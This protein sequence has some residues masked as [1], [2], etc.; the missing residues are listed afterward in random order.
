MKHIQILLAFILGT[1]AYN[2]NA[3]STSTTAP[4][5]S[6]LEERL[7]NAQVTQQKLGNGAVFTEIKFAG[8]LKPNFEIGCISIAEV[9]NQF[10]PPSLYLAA[11]KCIQT[12]QYEKA[13]AL[14]NTGNGFA[15]YDI[16]RLADISARGARAVLS[17]NV[18][19]DL[20]NAQRE[21]VSKVTKEIGTDPEKVRAYCVELTRI[22][23]PT[24]EP[25]WAILHGIGA[26]EEP[27][28]GPYLTKVD[29]KALWEEVLKNRC[30][31]QKP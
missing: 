19:A 24:Y 18:F 14:L 16:T 26:F 1:F 8:S 4:P 12:D 5:N 2:C 27:R 20:T 31:V 28:N 25:Q 22:G 23:V 6:I 13:W 11:K 7:K 17:M 9:T 30:T 15:Y 29:T 21:Q 3:Q 10:N